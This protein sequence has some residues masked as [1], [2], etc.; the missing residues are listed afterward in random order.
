MIQVEKHMEK[1]KII[2]RFLTCIVVV[3]LVIVVGA[4]ALFWNE[5]RTIS[6]MTKI[7]D[8]GAYQMTYYGDYGFDEF[9]EVGAQ[10]DA[11]I[12]NR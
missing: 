7:D 6:S 11:D 5:L 1:A 2:S 10:S 12:E 9:L 8:Y 4:I 3:L